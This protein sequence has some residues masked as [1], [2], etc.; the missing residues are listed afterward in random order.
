[1][2]DK[3]RS[4]LLRDIPDLIVKKLNLVKEDLDVKVDT[5][6]IIYLIDNWQGQLN[7]IEDLRDQIS[8]LE[9]KKK[10]LEDIVDTFKEFQNLLNDYKC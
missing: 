10:E 4:I 2:S 1:M 9:I 8:Q 6:A 5:K 3:K 7:H